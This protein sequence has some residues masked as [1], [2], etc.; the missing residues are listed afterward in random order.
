MAG[1][2][3][4]VAGKAQVMEERQKEALKNRSNKSSI[5]AIAAIIEKN[6]GESLLLLRRLSPVYS[7]CYL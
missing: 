4:W 5:S 6:T 7:K 3:I 2:E 1:K